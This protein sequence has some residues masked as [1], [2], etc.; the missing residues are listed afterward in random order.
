M[1]ENEK[2]MIMNAEIKEIEL[3]NKSKMDELL[4]TLKQSTQSEDKL[5]KDKRKLKKAYKQVRYN[6]VLY[7]LMN[8]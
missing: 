4:Q 1:E 6:I 2:L 5:K 7:K 8:E 3:F